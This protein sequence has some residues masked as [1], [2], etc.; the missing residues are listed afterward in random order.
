[1]V[2]LIP[3]FCP[4]WPTIHTYIMTCIHT[5]THTYLHT[6]MHIYIH[7]YI[8]DYIYMYEVKIVFH[9]NVALGGA[10]VASVG[11]L[12]Y[13]K[14]SVSVA[15]VAMTTDLMVRCGATSTMK[16]LTVRL[17]SS[18]KTCVPFVGSKS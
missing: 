11:I 5:Y 6:Y 8:L 7:T 16:E 13:P 17:C 15:D 12:K 1:M 10:N 3:D 18:C 4:L 2:T 14:R 9:Q